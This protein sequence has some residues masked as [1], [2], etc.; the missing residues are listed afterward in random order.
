MSEKLSTLFMDEPCTK[1][2][3]SQQKFKNITNRQFPVGVPIS[4]F[5]SYL[6]GLQAATVESSPQYYMKG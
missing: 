4:I 6:S 2:R 5:K 1:L 3:F